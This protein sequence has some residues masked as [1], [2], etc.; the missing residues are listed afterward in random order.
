[1]QL[2]SCSAYE[3]YFMMLHF[4]MWQLKGMEINAVGTTSVLGSSYGQGAVLKDV[5]CSQLTLSP[6]RLKCG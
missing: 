5:I 3:V 4:I 6:G 1:M 2:T